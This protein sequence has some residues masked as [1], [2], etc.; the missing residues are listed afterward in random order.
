M[1]GAMDCYAQFHS[2]ERYIQHININHTR[3]ITQLNVERTNNPVAATEHQQLSSQDPSDSE[4]L[5]QCPHP[6]CSYKCTS[7][8]TL[9]S[10]RFRYHKSA[11]LPETSANPTATTDNDLSQ[12]THQEPCSGALSFYSQGIEAQDTQVPN[13]GGGIEA[14][15]N[16]E[17][18]LFNKFVHIY[19]TLTSK[20]HIP[21]STL[22]YIINDYHLLLKHSLGLLST[23]LLSKLTS[24]GIDCDPLKPLIESIFSED[25]LIRLHSADGPMRSRYMRRQQYTKLFEFVNPISYN[26]GLNQNNIQRKY[27]YVSI[28]KTLKAFFDDTS[29]YEQY[30]ERKNKEVTRSHVLTDIEDGSL[31][32]THPVFSSDP[33]SIQLI[34]YQDDMEIVNPLGSGKGVYKLTAYYYTLANLHPWSRSSVDPLQLILLCRETDVAYFGLPRVLKPLIDELKKL[35]DHGLEIRGQNLKVNILVLLGDNLGTHTVSGFVENFSTAKYFC[36]Y[37]EESRDEWFSRMNRVSAGNSN[38]PQSDV[39][40]EASSSES[41][42]SCYTSSTEEE[43][44][45]NDETQRVPRPVDWLVNRPEGVKG[46]VADSQFNK[47][48]HYH[49][50]GATPPCLPHDIL[51]GLGAHDAK[52]AVT[53]LSKKYKFTIESL[54]RKIASFSFVGDESRDRPSKIGERSKTLGGQAVQNWVL[55]RFLPM[56]I[57]DAVTN[58]KDPV[59]RMV[60]LLIE[61]LQMITSP[62]ISSNI[63]PDLHN[64]IQQYLHLRK[65]NF[66]SMKLRPKHHFLEH[67]PKLISIFGPLMRLSTLRFESKHTFFKP[68]V[69]SQKNFKNITKSL[70]LSHQ[71]LQSSL[72][73]N[74]LF[75]NYP[76][77]KDDLPFRQCVLE[78][79]ALQCVLNAFGQEFANS[80]SASEKLSYHGTAY[81]KGKILVANTKDHPVLD[82]CKIILFLT[83]GK[84][85]YAVGKKYE[86]LLDP[87][88]QLYQLKYTGTYILVSLSEIADYVPYSIYRR[89]TNRVIVLKHLFFLGKSETASSG[90]AT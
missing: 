24:F 20:F 9:R 48:T 2:L 15:F 25:T 73:I 90:R 22:D 81:E 86:G 61:I 17:E 72:S 32:Q 67:Y 63:L 62:K 42:I 60:L 89:G 6:S 44:S 49:V 36:R 39:E 57:G 85:V 4:L 75:N 45:E 79:G 76:V 40:S 54:N 38:N 46:I 3:P 26:L 53:Y 5:I 69:R 18:I 52:L 1:C 7:K 88:L 11:T 83:R 87:D 77:L 84:A 78:D 13:D 19:L 12:Y 8:S 70:T 50:V 34:I 23:K 33:S 21:D 29:V 47:L 71:L 59:W 64:Q 41:E 65:I 66:P 51:E 28:E 82:L 80:M 30:T 10:H 74:N 43:G 58:K 14:D 56:L 31:F 37:C 35:E 68:A 27:H 55:I 16:S